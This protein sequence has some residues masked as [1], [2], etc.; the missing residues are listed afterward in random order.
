MERD[1]ALGVGVAFDNERL[2]TAK[3]MG[4]NAMPLQDSRGGTDTKSG[5]QKQI[6]FLLLLAVST[7]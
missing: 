3:K 6:T 1:F 7:R 2:G 4:P 5:S